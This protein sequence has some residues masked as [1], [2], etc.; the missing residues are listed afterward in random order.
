LHFALR[1]MN[2]RRSAQV[3]V[4]E[5]GAEPVAVSVD[6]DGT[7]LAFKDRVSTALWFN[8]RMMF[9]NFEG[10]QLDNNQALS[11][12][13]VQEGSTLHLLEVGVGPIGGRSLFAHGLFVYPK[14]K[15]EPRQKCCGEYVRFET[16]E[17][18]S[19]IARDQVVT[20]ALF[21]PV[22]HATACWPSMRSYTQSGSRVRVVTGDQV[23]TEHSLEGGPMLFLLPEGGWLPDSKYTIL[24]QNYQGRGVGVRFQ[25]KESPIFISK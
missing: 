21:E 16:V 25:T 17:M 22:L 4:K 1:K 12:Y 15:F 2:D 23:V 10:K 11:F 9:V 18:E 6:L 13:G 24:V 3:Y 19:P 8:G 7:V 14:L 5:V 20:V